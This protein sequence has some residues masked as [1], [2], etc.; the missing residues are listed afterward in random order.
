M[1][2]PTAGTRTTARACAARAVLP[3][4]FIGDRRGVDPHWAGWRSLRGFPFKKRSP[5]MI[6]RSILAFASALTLAAVAGLGTFAVGAKAQ[7]ARPAC[8]CCGASCACVS[9]SC[10]AS[11]VKV[12]DCGCCGG[13]TCCSAH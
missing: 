4:P 2:A 11:G 10:D 7:A 6:R 13:S 5:N 1:V 9:C 3:L 12:A 8:S